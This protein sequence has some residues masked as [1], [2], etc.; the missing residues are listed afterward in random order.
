[1][2]NANPTTPPHFKEKI[3]PPPL[4]GQISGAEL[5]TLR[6]DFYRDNYRRLMSICLLMTLIIGGL[7]GFIYFQRAT[8]PKP[9]YF[10]TNADGSLITMVPLNQPNLS[11]NALLAWAAEAATGVFN[12][13]FVHYREDLQRIQE[14]FTPAGYQQMLTALKESGNLDAVKTKKLVAS[15]V[16]TGSPVITKEGLI[17]NR[18]TWE[19]QIPMAVSYQS[20]TE[21]IPQKIVI[22]MLVTR[23]PTTESAKGIGIAQFIVREGELRL[24]SS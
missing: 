10:A 4:T 20:G 6:N 7:I 21:L 22:T 16:P 24:G 3:A 12:Y 14:F 9:T 2:D 19:M 5:V 18:Y 8:A 13:D 15:A 1:M 17:N 23:L 11:T